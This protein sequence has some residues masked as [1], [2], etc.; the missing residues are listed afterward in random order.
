MGVVA[1]FFAVAVRSCLDDYFVIVEEL[2][3][4][5][6][7]QIPWRSVDVVVVERNHDCLFRFPGQYWLDHCFQSQI[8]PIAMLSDEFL[9][10]P[11]S[12]QPAVSM[13]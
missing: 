3:Q 5:Q 13:E 9:L 12:V 8:S 10:P 11:D 4:K 2:M 6:I 7:V 1:F